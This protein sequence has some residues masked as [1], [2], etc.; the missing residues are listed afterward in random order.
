MA[1]GFGDN[2]LQGL[3]D[4]EI[5]LLKKTPGPVGSI[6]DGVGNLLQT[7]IFRLKRPIRSPMLQPVA[8]PR[9][10]TARNRNPFD[11]FGT[12]FTTPATAGLDPL[13]NLNQTMM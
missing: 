1:N 7:L 4:E 11:F 5:G 9:G 8:P 2:F 10:A 12:L 13:T 6:R 3:S